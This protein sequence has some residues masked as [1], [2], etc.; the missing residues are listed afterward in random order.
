MAFQFQISERYHF[1]LRRKTLS[2]LIFLVEDNKDKEDMSMRNK[3]NRK[4]KGGFDAKV[5]SGGCRDTSL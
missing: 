1:C 2:C 4:R 5:T 3:T